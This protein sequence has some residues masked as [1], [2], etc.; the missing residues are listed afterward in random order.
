MFSIFKNRPTNTEN[1]YINTYVCCIMVY[2]FDWNLVWNNLKHDNTIIY[3]DFT[4]P[5][6]SKS[7]TTS[8]V[9]MFKFSK[10]ESENL[11]FRYLSVI[12]SP[13]RLIAVCYN[14]VCV[15]SYLCRGISITKVSPHIRNRFLHSLSFKIF[16]LF[17]HWFFQGKQQKARNKNTGTQ[18]ANEGL[19]IIRHSFADFQKCRRCC[20]R[21]RI[22]KVAKKN[23]LFLLYSWH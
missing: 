8:I 14:I 19:L 10:R 13:K 12:K 7:F 18:Q 20:V 6:F 23:N 17:L 1:I 22:A 16:F 15:L 9:R 3:D 21:Q 2:N 4:S 5:D 11:K